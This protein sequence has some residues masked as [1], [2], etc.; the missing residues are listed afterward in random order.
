MPKGSRTFDS[1]LEV[2]D[3]DGV[4]ITA[5]GDQTAAT[6]SGLLGDNSFVAVFNIISNAGTPADSDYF[7]LGLEVSSDGTNYYPV[8]EVQSSWDITGAAAQTGLFEVAFTGNQAVE[9]AGGSTP[10][11]VRVT[12][13]KVSTA[14]T[15]IVAGCYL[16]KA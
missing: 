9:A 11:H 15:N 16:A 2:L 1:L 14:Q 13:V 3:I 6:I 5:S 10:T 12:A 4:T 7:T 8:G